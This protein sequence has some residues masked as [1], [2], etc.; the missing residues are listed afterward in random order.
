MSKAVLLVGGH[1]CRYCG[2]HADT[3]DHIVPRRDGGSDEAKN[4]VPA[5]QPCN[6]RKGGARLPTHIEKELLIEAF[7]NAPQVDALVHSFQAAQ[8]HAGIRDPIALQRDPMDIW[9][10][11]GSH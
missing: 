1:R 10:I 4:L 11:Q 2:A 6:S 5:C 3:A 8:K 9:K 7:I